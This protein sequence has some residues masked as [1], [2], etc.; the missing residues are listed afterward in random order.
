[1][2]KRQSM[3][4]LNGEMSRQLVRES[5][6]AQ[7]PWVRK[8][9]PIICG[10]AMKR[11]K[12]EPQLQRLFPDLVA[13]GLLA[14]KESVELFSATGRKAAELDGYVISAVK[15]AFRRRAY[16]ESTL[17]GPSYTTWKRNHA[18]LASYAW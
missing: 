15:R 17:V 14:L 5:K 18:R 12:N 3:M 1:M 4:E 2:A 13:E 10:L 7:E 11:V 9:T 16:C 8:F 6:T